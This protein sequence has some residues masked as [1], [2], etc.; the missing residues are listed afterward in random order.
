MDQHSKPETKN[1]T[2][3]KT[4]AISWPKIPVKTPPRKDQIVI[5]IPDNDCSTE[6]A[7]KTFSGLTNCGID[8]VLAGVKSDENITRNTLATYTIQ[9]S[10]SERTNIKLAATMARPKSETNSTIF[11]LSLSV[12]I[13]AIGPKIN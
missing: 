11:L 6:L 9:I 8:E 5:T 12:K 4:K 2:A 13:P 7:T 10:E 3:L 1:D